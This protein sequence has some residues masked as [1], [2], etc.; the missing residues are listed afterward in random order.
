MIASFSNMMIRAKIQGGI[1]MQKKRM[2]GAAMGVAMAAS[3]ATS[4]FAAWA[5]SKTQQEVIS[6]SGSAN[7]GGT[8]SAVT[9]I[10]NGQKVPVGYP[11]TSTGNLILSQVSDPVILVTPLSHTQLGNQ[12]MGE[13]LDYGDKAA[14][15]TESGLTY[16]TN[17]KTN[18]VYQTV[19]N[20]KN[21][22]EFLSK[23]SGNIQNDVEALIA[24]KIAAKK[25]ELEDQR[26]KAEANGDQTAVA[27]LDKQL[28]ALDE[29]DYASVDNYS[30]LAVFDVSAND[31]FLGQMNEGDSVDLT[32]EVNGVNENSDLIALHFTGDIVDCDAAIQAVNTDFANATVDF[33]VEVLDVSTQDGKATFTLSSF[34]PV[35]LLSRVEGQSSEEPVVSQKP[36]TPQTSDR[37]NLQVW[38][39]LGAT[40]AVAVV[41]MVAA[42]H[43]KKP[44][45][46][47]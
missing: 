47:K 9:T 18:L 31:A 19:V 21:T 5:P 6:A 36:E 38:I 4:A 28:A 45:V 46:E 43:K 14:L 10:V 26:T 27:A 42:V 25:A 44:S 17:A 22:T 2:M 37:S 11:V 32:V 12:G 30:P 24:Q 1:D 34:S 33:T 15:E 23:F 8:S 20:A 7:I 41:A 3:L 29:A 35:M 13:G 40:A 16:G 39:T